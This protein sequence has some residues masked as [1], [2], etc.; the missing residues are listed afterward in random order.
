MNCDRT[1]LHCDL[2]GF[3]AS[4]EALSHPEIGDAPMAVAGDV[5]SRHGIIL[6]KNEAAKKFGVSTAEPV[7]QAKRK[8]PNLLLLP[9]NHDKYAMYSRKVNEIYARY[10]NKVEPFGIDESWLDITMS[11]K[12]FGDGKKVA[13]TLRETVKKELGLTISV[14]V[15]FN[16][17]FAK[18]A[19]DYKKPDATTIFDRSAMSIIRALPAKD[20][21]FI[22]KT[23]ATALAGMGIRTIGELADFNQ[24]SLIMRF[25]KFGRTMSE[26]ARGE[27][28]SEVADFG[29]VE[30]AKSIGNSI[31]FAR[32]LI[33]KQD[34]RVGFTKVAEKVSLRLKE[35]GVKCGGIQIVVKGADFSRI[36]RQC[37]IDKPTNSISQLVDCAMT[38]AEKSWNFSEPVRLL[39]ISGHSFSCE[40]APVQGELFVDE[41]LKKSERRDAA[42][43][44]FLEVR[45]K[46]G[47]GSIEFGDIIDF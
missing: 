11:L 30:E 46:F 33:G 32:D 20:M 27:D 24:R 21:L 47:K 14:G 23:T 12:L 39:G 1:I 37:V 29:S 17:V 7:W 28:Y 9:P 22:G 6:A 10:T 42:E 18:L 45:K 25:G 19:S 2:N 43:R 41:N 3:F 13:D 15:S 16:K 5:K 31:T 40:N 35:E 26:Y 36:T 4:V 44:A 38:L 34:V 8:C